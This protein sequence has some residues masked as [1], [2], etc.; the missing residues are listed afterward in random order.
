MTLQPT[1]DIKNSIATKLLTH[2]FSIY[3]LIAVTATLIHMFS[4]YY[5]T[6]HHVVENLK[7]FQETFESSLAQALWDINVEQVDSIMAGI[8]K[9]PMITGI[10]IKSVMGIS[11][12]GIILNENKEMFVIDPAESFN[13]S[14]HQN[15]GQQGK[16]ISMADESASSQVFWHQFKI[17][18]TEVDGSKKQVGEATIYSNNRVVF[19]QLKHSFIFILVNAGIKTIA[20]WVIFLYFGRI[21]LSRPLS[22]LTH[23]TKA[24]NLDQLDDFHVDIQTKGRTELKIL[25]EAFNN[26]VEKLR[27]AKLVIRDNIRM[28]G[29]LKTAAAV[30][31]ALFPKQIP[32]VNNLKLAGFFQSATETG[33]D[34]YGFITELDDQLYIMIGDVTG[35]GTPAALVTATAS[36]TCKTIKEIFT[37]NGKNRRNISPSLILQ[38]LNKLVLDAGYSKFLMT[39]FI[40]KIDLAT[41]LMTFSNAAHNF[42]IVIRANGDA[43]HLLS[44]GYRLGNLEDPKFT[45]KTLQLEMDD[46]LFFY[47]DGLTETQ[48][49]Q[50]EMWGERRLVRY[51][52]KHR[53]LP[54]E[55]LVHNVVQESYRFC[56]NRPLEDDV[57]IVTCRVAE[58][59][60]VTLN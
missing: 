29:E 25:E 38:K 20:L 2:V 40:A 14:P 51:L 58:P 21:L 33:G 49:E 55:E 4:E 56:N 28:E 10:K 41:G 37:Y 15:W 47:T 45:E 42:P 1:V 48:N 26:M 43:I 34:W 8:E 32:Q 31:Q 3:L 39:F 60:T 5:N 13:L 9:I 17:F 6:K 35:H 7:M 12:K 19:Q 57:T 50:G 24:L 46:L 16:Q 54:I 59:F 30:Q 27:Q 52:K 23:A 22:R 44:R 36:A 18:H 53:N 11:G